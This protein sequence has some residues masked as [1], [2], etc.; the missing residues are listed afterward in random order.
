MP[1]KRQEGITTLPRYK[2]KMYA[3]A[4]G[5]F[6]GNEELAKEYAEALS[7]ARSQGFG[8]YR[9]AWQETKPILMKHEVPSALWGLYKAFV[10]ELI[11]KVQRRKIATVEEIIDKWV[12]NGLDEAVL[13]DVAEAVVQVFEKAPSPAEKVA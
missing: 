2:G 13:R 5:I 4:F 8:V 1:R 6:A 12:G 10:N 3:V 11:N 9:V 7:H